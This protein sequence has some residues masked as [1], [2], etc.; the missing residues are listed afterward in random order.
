MSRF[1]M[2]RIATVPSVNPDLDRSRLQ[3]AWLYAAAGALVIV[4][5]LILVLLAAAVTGFAHLSSEAMAGM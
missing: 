1:A 5:V 3:P 2:R 4:A